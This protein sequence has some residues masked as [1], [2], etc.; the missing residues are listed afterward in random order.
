MMRWDIL[1]IGEMKRN[2]YLGRTHKERHVD[3]R[4]ISEGVVL[5][6]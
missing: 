4:V 6:S 1:W 5:C 2:G 3:L